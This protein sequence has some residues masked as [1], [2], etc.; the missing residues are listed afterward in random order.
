M[1]LRPADLQSN[2]AVL[3]HPQRHPEAHAQLMEWLGQGGVHIEK[4]ARASHSTEMH[5]LVKAGYGLALIREGIVL[6]AGLTTRPI[7]GVKWAVDTAFVHNRQVHPKTV[8]VLLRN[9]KK[10]LAVQPTTGRSPEVTTAPDFSNGGAKRPPG[11]ENNGQSKS[12]S[13]PP[14]MRAAGLWAPAAGLA[15]SAFLVSRENVD[16][17]DRKN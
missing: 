8:P 2:L 9:L 5:A 4:F 10:R 15:D 11:S 12:S 7:A 6:D 13:W 17:K 16:R 14:R 3:Y 1:V